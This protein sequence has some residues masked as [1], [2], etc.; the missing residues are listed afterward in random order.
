MLIRLRHCFSINLILTPKAFCMA[1]LLGATNGVWG[2]PAQQTG[3]L[4]EG[5]T[6]AYKCQTKNVMNITGDKTGRSDYDEDCVINLTA[7][8]P[9]ASAFSGTISTTI[10][11]ETA[12]TNHLIGGMSAGITIIDTIDVSQAADDYHGI[13]LAATYSP[14]IVAS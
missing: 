10:S 3:F 11:L 5:V 2:I 7:K 12:P 1:T 13:T 6:W 9:A 4:L 14:T 8:I